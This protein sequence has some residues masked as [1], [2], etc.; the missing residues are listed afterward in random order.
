MAVASTV[1]SA[2]M[3]RCGGSADDSTPVTGGVIT[4]AGTTGFTTSAV[5]E[6][7]GGI[8]AGGAVDADGTTGFTTSAD[9][10]LAGGMLA[11]GVVDAG[12]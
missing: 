10:E 3:G 2:A 1:A 8:I 12:G 6:L 5:A 11:G 4:A 7:A 9:A